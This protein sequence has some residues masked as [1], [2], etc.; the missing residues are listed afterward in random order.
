MLQSDNQS[1]T[2]RSFNLVNESVQCIVQNEYL[3]RMN[4]WT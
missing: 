2:N 3:H 4:V 1:Q